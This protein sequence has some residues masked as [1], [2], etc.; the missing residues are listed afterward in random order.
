MKNGYFRVGACT[1]KLRVA[2]PKENAE[3]ILEAVQDAVSK[4][5]S[6]LVFPELCITGYTCSDLFL[7]KKLQDSAIDALLYLVDQTKELPII[8]AVGI[9]LA[10][11]NK[12]YNCAAI[13]TGGQILGFVPKTNL[14]NYAEF[15]ECR[16]FS[17]GPAN[18]S[19]SIRGN[20]YPF[21]TDQLFICEEFDQCRFAVEICE[22]LWV[23]IPPSSHHAEMGATLILN[24]SASDETIAKAA[25]RRSLISSQ[26]A[27]LICG[28]VYADAGFGE[29]TTDM[30]FAGHNLIY[31]NGR[32]LS[33][34]SLFSSGIIF[35]D[36]DF[37]LLAQDRIRQSSYQNISEDTDRN[38]YVHTHYSLSLQD[39]KT[40]RVCNPY[41]FV[42]S[43]ILERNARCE[44]I[45]SI[46]ATGL[47]TRLAH[48][49]ITQVVIGMSGGLDST[50]AFLVAIRAFTLLHLPFSGIHAITMPGFGTT[51][52]TYSN[53][54]KLSSAYNTSFEEISI[55][56]AVMQHF[57]D[58]KQDLETYDITYENSQA[59]ERTQ[60]LMD[61]ANKYCGL[62]IGTGDLS[63]LAL[64]FATY[65]GDHMSMYAVNS[66]VPKTL[67]RYLVMYAAGISE[68]DIK[69]VLLDVLDTPVSPELLP[70]NNDKISQVTEDFVGPY[71][72]H[73]FF[74]YYFIRY[75]F[76]PE[77][78]YDMAVLSFENEYDAK[79]IR[80]WCRLFIKR[81]FSQQFKRSCLPD[82]PKVGS[83][84]LSPRGDWRMPSDASSFIWT[85]Q[86]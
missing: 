71:A 12:L 53:A 58:I 1:P 79:T 59:R 74:L 3:F 56:K 69:Q 50:L 78:L 13:I 11:N 32:I 64:G 28:Y 48:T 85:L 82:G 86:D 4:G 39:T 81:F 6:L 70:H 17:P 27:R 26:S 20:V 34:S 61:L 46:Q 10:N 22:D 14:P 37:E 2:N 66:S 47:A 60:I 31:E 44:E 23:P 75:G 15:Y 68:N 40:V 73:D 76:T 35:Q 36:I 62:V 38:Q 49:G 18:G 29:S 33:E 55:D 21:G 57:T 84:S 24:L 8:F 51:T 77:K 80:K 63:E 65:N 16:H 25:Y 7:Q 83:V 67:V 72:L 42:P 41:P 45:F 5:I 19:I 54:C 52:R 9:P 30:V 43:D